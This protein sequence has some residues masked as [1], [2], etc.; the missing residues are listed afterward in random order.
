MDLKEKSITFQISDEAYKQLYN[1]AK[2]SELSLPEFIKSFALLFIDNKSFLKHFS[3]ED[4]KNYFE[5]DLQKMAKQL[6]NKRQFIDLILRSIYSTQL[7]L[8]VQFKKYRKEAE[9]E[10]KKDVD[11]ITLMV[12]SSGS[13]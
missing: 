3:I 12:D 10:L 2:T 7:R 9:K 6:E 13:K 8:E 1:L 5:D 4:S 11:R